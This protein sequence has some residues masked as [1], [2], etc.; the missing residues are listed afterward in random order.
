[1]TKL[2]DILNTEINRDTANKVY[3]PVKYQIVKAA[4]VLKKQKIGT[5]KCFL[6]SFAL[7]AAASY[8]GYYKA[9]E[10]VAKGDYTKA[11]AYYALGLPLD[12]AGKIF[13]IAGGYLLFR[14]AYKKIKEKVIKRAHGVKNYYK[15]NFRIF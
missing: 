6:Y 12:Y 13:F 1:M 3:R 14:G 10:E 7:N 8:L 15:N 5:L 4:R 11:A 2:Q 9:G